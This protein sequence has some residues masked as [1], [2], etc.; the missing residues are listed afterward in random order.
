MLP[1][2]F[3]YVEKATFINIEGANH[4]QMTVESSPHYQLVDLIFILYSF[5]LIALTTTWLKTH[6]LFGLWLTKIVMM[7]LLMM[8]SSDVSQIIR[9]TN[10]MINLVIL[11]KYLNLQTFLCDVEDSREKLDR[12]FSYNFLFFDDE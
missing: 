5:T 12:F 11:Y 6:V 2:F 3:F 8:K 4:Y 10:E 1:D 7:A 9:D